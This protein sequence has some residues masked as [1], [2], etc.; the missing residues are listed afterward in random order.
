MGGAIAE[1]S[2]DIAAVD[3]G[4]TQNC[5]QGAAWQ[6]PP[7]YRYDNPTAGDGMEIDVVTAFHT[8]EREPL[9]RQYSDDLARRESG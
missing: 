8:I 6:V 7:V 3:T 2:L 9:L 4:L 5:E 1:R